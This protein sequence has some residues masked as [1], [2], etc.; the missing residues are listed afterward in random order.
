MKKKEV[1]ESPFNTDKKKEGERES[2]FTKNEMLATH[3]QEEEERRV[4]YLRKIT[5]ARRKPRTKEL[6][7]N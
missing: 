2:L 3:R 4:D 6:T 5:N 7:Q 1:K